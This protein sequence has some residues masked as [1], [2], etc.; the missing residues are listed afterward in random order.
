MFKLINEVKSKTPLVVHFT[1]EVTVNDCANITL[2]IGASP[3]MSSYMDDL[4]DIVKIA[5]SIV[6]NIGTINRET[7]IIFKEV[8]RL[9][10]IYDK[11]IVLD[12]VGVFASPTRFKY[13]KELLEIN[14]FTVI[15]GN[16]AEIKAIGGI[17]SSGQGVDSLDND[18]NIQVIKELSKKFDYDRYLH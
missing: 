1:N 3:I 4:E 8:A 7:S 17:E 10:K 16:I 13:V 14:S 18:I 9:A 2:A 15:K 12:P 6:V 11:K 5:S